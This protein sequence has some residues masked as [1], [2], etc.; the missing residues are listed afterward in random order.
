M[1]PWRILPQSRSTTSEYQTLYHDGDELELRLGGE[2][3]DGNDNNVDRD[4]G[5]NV[6]ENT[7]RTSSD[8]DVDLPL[9]PP[10]PRPAFNQTRTSLRRIGYFRRMKL[11]GLS[12]PTRNRIFHF[13]CLFSA[14]LIVGLLW[15]G[16]PPDYQDIRLYEKKL[17]QHRLTG[18]L[19]GDGKE[20]YLRFSGSLWGHGLNNVLQERYV[21]SSDTHYYKRKPTHRN[22]FLMAYLAHR[23]DRSY[24]F[25]EYTW[26][27]S[28][29]QWTIYDFA[30]RPT[31]IPLSAFLAG[32][33]V[34]GGG[35]SLGSSD[36]RQERLAVSAE[37]WE[38]VCPIKERAVV[39][40]GEAPSG[41]VDGEVLM[42][43]WVEKL[44]NFEGRRC[45]EV[46][47]TSGKIFDMQ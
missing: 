38:T 33:I 36:G 45:V 31:R 9:L 1:L 41:D 37:F 8:T 44:K 3:D 12:L 7:P 6:E 25:E 2:H 11:R 47:S 40:V 5:A 15:S 43:W 30:L 10:P 34:G 19:G 42:Q 21:L 17:P 24:V 46:D 39:S 16:I 14:L 20:R 18:A 22:R 28:P 32:P 4:G 29:F 26:S 23:A 35:A 27:R 13:L